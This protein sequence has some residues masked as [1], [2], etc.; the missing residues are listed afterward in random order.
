MRS[1]FPLPGRQ[2]ATRLSHLLKSKEARAQS[3]DEAI[4][5]WT[6]LP[7]NQDSR[8]LFVKFSLSFLE[9]FRGGGGAVEIVT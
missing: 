8:G 3:C 7:L 1:L 6:V 4:R 5:L 2:N 9:V